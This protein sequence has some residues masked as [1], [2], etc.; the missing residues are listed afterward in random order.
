M[1]P[2]RDAGSELKR[3][4][5]AKWDVSYMKLDSNLRIGLLLT[6]PTSAH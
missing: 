4:I 2:C 1:P 5:F 3:D 6:R